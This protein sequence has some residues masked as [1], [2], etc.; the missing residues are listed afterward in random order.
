MP[1]LTSGG[2]TTSRGA[3]LA[4]LQSDWSN[5]Q[6]CYNNNWIIKAGQ[7]LWT[8]NPSK[9]SDNIN[10][11]YCFNETAILNNAYPYG[12]LDIYPVVYLKNSIQIVSGLGTKENPFELNL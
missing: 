10:R 12:A 5:Y 9:S 8:M 11:I 4:S 7:T 1:F 2:Q 6:D 3:C